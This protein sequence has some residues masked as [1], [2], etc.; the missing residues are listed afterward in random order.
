MST[1]DRGIEVIAL[2]KMLKAVLLILAGA[3]MLSLLRPAEAAEVHEWLGALTMV[4]GQ[5]IIHRALSLLD[6]TPLHLGSIGVASICY[7]LL[8]ALE[9]VG[10][11][12]ERRWAEYLTVF[13]TGSLVPLEVYELVRRVSWPRV[14][15]LVVNIAAV[16]YLIVRLRPRPATEV[17]GVGARRT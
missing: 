8:F 11:W 3:G 5:Q 12:L 6:A 4:R 16:A 1:R 13:A 10:L 2:F 9:G 17:A 15:A 14:L 7:G